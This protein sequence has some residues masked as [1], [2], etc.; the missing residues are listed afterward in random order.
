MSLQIR[1]D[2]LS[3]ERRVK[4]SGFRLKHE[5]VRMFLSSLIW[6]LWGKAYAYVCHFVGSKYPFDYLGFCPP[7]QPITIILIER[8]QIHVTRE[9]SYTSYEDYTDSCI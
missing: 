5:K 7:K 2:S 8:C 4:I 3:N 1:Y 6:S 9:A